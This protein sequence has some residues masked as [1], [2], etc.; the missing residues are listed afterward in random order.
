MK[1]LLK[2]AQKDSDQAEVYY[3]RSNS[4]SMSIRDGKATEMSA[5]I[6]S[7]YAIRLLKDGKIGSAYTKNLH[8]ASELIENGRASL[9]G[10]VEASFSFPGQTELPDADM[11]DS[12]IET[13]TYSDL[14]TRAAE[15]L[16]YL[17]GKV[18]GL[19]DIG[20]G[21]GTDETA[22][23]NTN[24]LD[25]NQKSSIY[26]IYMS[27]LFPHT[28][29]G[30]FKMF[31]SKGIE[32][33]P[34]DQVDKLIELYKAGLP[35]VNISSG[36]MKV[37]FM[38]NSIYSLI[39]RLSVATQGKSFYNK[40]SPLLNKMGEQILSE[41]F[42]LY[43]D[44]AASDAMGRR[45][46]DDEGVPTR[47]HYIIEK[48]KFK[49]LILNLDYA[50]KLNMEPT[51][52]GFRGGMWGGDAISIPPVPSLLESR[53]APGNTSFEDMIRS[54]N[55]GVIVFGLLGAHSGNILN[56]DMSVGLNPGYYVENGKIIGRVKDGMLAGNVYDMLN[57]IVSIEDKQHDSIMGGK[58]PAI[59]L[60]KVSVSAKK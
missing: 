27:L 23:A 42:S 43:G 5:S 7:G 51:G 37:M 45:L 8:N 9:K 13:I 60:D 28:E 48:G 46:F 44:P 54:I 39:W 47:K 36:E 38:P 12:K 14:H 53:I 41:K 21:Y 35:E 20:V 32:K 19:V 3:T 10:N 31:S 6:Q 56:G 29:T 59:L 58:Y 34:Q 52:N 15:L 17:E 1:E 18:D 49:N 25:M 40:V 11:F 57:R 30:I 33:F 26:Y 2:K 24:G 22:I 16:D 55:R 50:A 4:G